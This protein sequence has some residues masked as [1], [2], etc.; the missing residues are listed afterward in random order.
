MR[1]YSPEVQFFVEMVLGIFLRELGE[2]LA[3]ITK[4]VDQSLKRLSVPIQKYLLIDL[5]QL[6]HIREHLGQQR[7]GNGL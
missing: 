1:V 5:L 7:V 3:M 6:M 2:H 4:V